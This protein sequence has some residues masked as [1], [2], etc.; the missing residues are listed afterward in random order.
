MGI[1][2]VQGNY[3]TVCYEGSD[4]KEKTIRYQNNSSVFADDVFTKSN[5]G[6]TQIDTG[7][8]DASEET[9]SS[10]DLEKGGFFKSLGNGMVFNFKSLIPIWSSKTA[11][12]IEY[13]HEAIMEELTNGDEYNINDDEKGTAKT[14]GKGILTK[15]AYMI[16]FYGTYKLGKEALE[17]EYA[18]DKLTD[19]ENTGDYEK[20]GFFKCF[21][22]GILKNL[23]L[24]VPV[25][26]AYTKGKD[27]DMQN[28]IYE[29]LQKR[30]AESQ[31][32]EIEEV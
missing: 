13:Q 3:Q 27:I 16:P 8:S 4:A 7:M 29:E 10:A 24:M 19:P 21:G 20:P 22:K 6:L 12:D 26:S 25:L 15:L 14:V 31:T 28:Q 1:G 11:G 30:E 18:Y 9:Q 5:D 17:N 32:T 23:A 2:S